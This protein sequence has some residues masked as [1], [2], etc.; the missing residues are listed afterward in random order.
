MSEFVS[1]GPAADFVPGK[2]KVVKVDGR[3]VAVTKVEE[4]FYAFA[5]LCTH[6]L[7]PM[8]LGYVKG[9]EAICIY[10]WASFDATTGAVIQGPAY[11]PLQTYEVR[12]ENG[13]VQVGRAKEP[14]V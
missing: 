6:S 8:H 7:H 4:G 14:I 12:V 5:N 2:M 1:A 11:E 13:E 9:K 10:H 3:E